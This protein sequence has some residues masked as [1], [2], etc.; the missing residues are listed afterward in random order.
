MNNEEL[1]FSIEHD[2]Y[3]TKEEMNRIEEETILNQNLVMELKEQYG[4]LYLTIVNDIEFIF[5]PISPKEYDALMD[6]Y[7]DSLIL[8]EIVCKKSIISPELDDWH[9]NTDGGYASILSKEILKA[10]WITN[11]DFKYINKEFEQR[12]IE[13]DTSLKEQIPLIIYSAFNYL[14]I[15]EIESWNFKKQIE[16]L[17]KANYVLLRTGM[18]EEIKLEE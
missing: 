5:R 2:D 13:I 1:I 17:A 3:L 12:K 4:D 8:Q 16:W 14:T 11:V 7:T 18:A 6:I 10:S 15:E 9:F